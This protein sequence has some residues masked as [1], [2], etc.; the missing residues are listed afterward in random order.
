MKYTSFK[1]CRLLVAVICAGFFMGSCGGEKGKAGQDSYET[2]KESLEEQEKKHPARFLSANGSRKKNLIGQTVV[3][4]II[5]NK[6]SVVTYKD[7]ELKLSFY[8]QT[9]A[10][11]EE[12][13]ETIY[14]SVAPGAEVSFKT[15]YFAPKGTDSV[16]FRVVKAKF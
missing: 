1:V 10:L 16:S 12:D 15:K 8:S 6:A 9:G 7:I 3:R 4:G 5:R 13:H 11:L 14:E 2:A